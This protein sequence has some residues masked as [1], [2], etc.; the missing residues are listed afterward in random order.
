MSC[1][2]LSAAGH[3]GTFRDIGELEQCPTYL[4]E[5]RDPWVD[6]VV[7]LY[8]DY[9]AGVVPGWPD[10]YAAGAANAVRFLRGESNAC[11]NELMEAAHGGR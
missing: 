8:N 7:R 4:L 6:A 2:V 10:N 1:R 5:Q 3:A 9:D 11:H